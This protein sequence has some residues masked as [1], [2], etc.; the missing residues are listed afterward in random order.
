[1]K[2]EV[3]DVKKEPYSLPGG[4]EWSAIDLKDEV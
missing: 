3:K 2:Q 4:F 1:M